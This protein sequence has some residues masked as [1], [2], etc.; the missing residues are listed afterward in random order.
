MNKQILIA[1]IVSLFFCS[2]NI[3]SVEIVKST[4]FKTGLVEVKFNLKGLYFDKH[5]QQETVFFSDGEEFI[6]TYS[7]Q[8]G[9]LDS[10]PLK[11]IVGLYSRRPHFVLP[12]SRDT[13]FCGQY[14]GEGI[15]VINSAGD[16]YHTVT[17]DDALP[18]SLKGLILAQHFIP[19]PLTTPNK[20]LFRNYLSWHGLM[21]KEYK[22]DLNIVAQH[23]FFCKSFHNIPYFIELNNIFSDTAE[24]RLGLYDYYKNNFAE[25]NASMSE[26]GFFK[27]ANS[28][29]FLL[30][31][32]TGKIFKINPNSFEVLQE[33]EVKSQFTEIKSS[34][35]YMDLRN[36]TEALKTGELY[37]SVIG[38]LFYDEKNGKYLVIVLHSVNT[39]EEFD[40]FEAFNYRPFSIIAY[41]ANFENPVEYNFEG[42]TYNARISFMCSEGFMIQRKPENLTVHNYGTQT[43]DLLKFN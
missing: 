15:A 27:E 22:T 37:K 25:N 5:L 26:S 13:I 6:K 39:Q 12:Y 8:G 24:Y 34:Y 35:T 1:G 43:F 40:R 21:K 4:D 29:V 30:C 3:N 2:C 41:D 19:Y 28:F 20:I 32:A 7:L 23:G 17:V 11:N 16:V 9:L 42:N 38:E 18:D 14:F 31:S 33:I 36:K 10:I